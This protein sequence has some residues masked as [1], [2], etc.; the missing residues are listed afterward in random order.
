MMYKTEFSGVIRPQ[1]IV[2]EVYKSEDGSHKEFSKSIADVGT[3]QENLAA[4]TYKFDVKPPTTGRYVKVSKN[5]PGLGLCEVQVL[6]NLAE[7]NIKSVFWTKSAQVTRHNVAL[8]KPVTYHSVHATK[9]YH[10][11]NKRPELTNNINNDCIPQKAPFPGEQT[12]N[13]FIVTLSDPSEGEVTPGAHYRVYGV[14]ISQGCSP[15]KY[16]YTVHVGM[17]GDLKFRHV[18]KATVCTRNQIVRQCSTKLILCERMTVGTHVRV[19]IDNLRLAQI[20]ICNI[21]V[22]GR[23]Y[24]SRDGLMNVALYKYARQSGTHTTEPAALAVDGVLKRV[25]PSPEWATC[26]KATM[27]PQT[28]KSWWLVDLA[29]VYDIEAVNI[30]TNTSQTLTLV[31]VRVYLDDIFRWLANKGVIHTLDQSYDLC[32]EAGTLEAGTMHLRRCNE[33]LKG[34]HVKVIQD[35][36][37]LVLCEVEVMARPLL[38][39]RRFG[40]PYNPLSLTDNTD[41]RNGWNASFKVMNT[42]EFNSTVLCGDMEQEDNTYYIHSPNY[43]DKYT[44]PGFKYICQWVVPT[45]KDGITVVYI[46]HLD[47]APRHSGRMCSAEALLLSNSAGEQRTLCGTMGFRHYKFRAIKDEFFYVSLVVQTP[48]SASD[49]VQHSGFKMSVFS[50]E[51]CTGILPP[52][53][54][55][56]SPNYPGSSPMYSYCHWTLVPPKN[57]TIWFSVLD[58][59]IKEDCETGGVIFSWTSVNGTEQEKTFCHSN[60][61]RKPLEVS[62]QQ[63]QPLTISFRTGSSWSSGS[64]FTLQ[65][66]KALKCGKPFLQNDVEYTNPL[67]PV[68]ISHIP[69]CVLRLQLDLEDT[70]HLEIK[71]HDYKFNGSANICVDVWTRFANKHQITDSTCIPERGTDRQESN[72]KEPTVT[73]LKVKA[74]SRVLFTWNFPEGSYGKVRFSMSFKLSTPGKY[75]FVLIVYIV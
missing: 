2:V 15:K 52:E 26:T 10:T 44:E 5:S 21:Q 25:G 7:N 62:I 63:N 60:S 37:D 28:D 41:S 47:L 16:N 3:A 33:V 64:R 8:R 58:L 61:A 22:Y 27:E 23:L 42:K 19:D 73:T 65:Y 18:T 1:D 67:Y 6:I 24:G 35:A 29:N 69:T 43:P 30:Q 68:M 49:F 39:D 75:M 13:F 55:L 17:H 54:V 34:R 9:P 20:T 74:S 53:G 70:G 31:E 51:D 57:T 50:H 12:I 45:K 72:G 32:Y 48:E 66:L 56:S 59:D 4:Y 36:S 40:M 46:P 38:S 11:V 71:W 14:M